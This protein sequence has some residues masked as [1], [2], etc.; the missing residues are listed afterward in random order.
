[1]KKKSKLNCHELLSMLFLCQR[2]SHKKGNLGGVYFCFAVLDSSSNLG[3]VE[4]E[5]RVG[6]NCDQDS[7]FVMDS[8]FSIFVAES[9][10]LS[11]AV[12]HS[13]PALSPA[14]ATEQESMQ[15]LNSRSVGCW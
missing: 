6:R 4:G 7:S 5:H 11:C 15:L 14:L 9:G 2:T 12:S 10:S 1:M 13:M 8:S 3:K